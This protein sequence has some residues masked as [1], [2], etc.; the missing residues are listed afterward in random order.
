[1][2]MTLMMFPLLALYIAIPI[3]IGVYVWKDAK[4]R[5]MNAPLWTIVAVF[6]PTFIGLII[7]LLVRGNYSDMKCPKCSAPVRE[8]YVVCPKCG[9]K[10][11]PNCQNCGTAVDPSWKVCPHCASTLPEVQTDYT[12]PVKPKDKTLIGV[13][14]IIILVPVIIIVML[15]LNFSG[16]SGGASSLTTFTID[17]YLSE[18]ENEDIEAWIDEIGDEYGKA[19]VLKNQYET[20]D[21]IRVRYL[22]Y[23]PRLVDDPSYSFGVNGGLFGATFKIEFPN[24]NGNCGNTL[25]LATFNGE[26]EPKLKIYYDGK[27][28]DC[29]ITEVDYPIGLTDGSKYAYDNTSSIE[30][31]VPAGSITITEENVAEVEP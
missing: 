26:K 27:L 11:R 28:L 10:L 4:Q 7:F 1:M 16:G 30:E 19:Y 3:I 15:L 13:L 24:V 14:G 12:S 29:E 20:D 25:V 23:S 8:S 5:G 17:Q 6:A 31:G 2:R 9:A 21:G 18:M 22:I